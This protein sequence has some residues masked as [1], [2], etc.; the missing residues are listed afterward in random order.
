[1]RFLEALSAK[2]DATREGYRLLLPVRF[3]FLTVLVT[4]VVLHFTDQGKDAVAALAEG[5]GTWLRWISFAA[6]VGLFA[7]QTWYWSRQLLR[8]HY[9]GQPYPRRWPRTTRW[10]PRLLGFT[11]FVAVIVVLARVRGNY[12]GVVRKPAQVLFWLIVVLAIEA[13]VFVAFVIVRRKRIGPVQTVERLR[14]FGPVTL[15]ILGITALMAVIVL[16][17]STFAVQSA[18]HIGAISVLIIA[19]GFWVAL[20]GAV[21]HAGMRLRIPIL[22][23]LLL[24][25]IVIS[26]LAENHDVRTVPGPMP[27]RPDA[28]AAFAAWYARLVAETPNAATPRPVFIVAT[29]GGGVRAAYWTAA[30]LTSLHDTVPGFTSH[31]FGIS[32]ASGGSV[33]AATYRT[34]LAEPT[35]HGALR[36]LARD[37]L[38]Y[39]VLAP[40]LAAYM[41]QDFVQR[42]LPLG[43][44]DRARA[45]E[46]GWE[47][48]WSRA[49]HTQ[50]FGEGFLATTTANADRF[51]SLFLNGTLVETGR[52][53]IG[54]NV[55]IDNHFAYA[56]DAFD[57]IHADV[58]VSTAAH[59]SSRFPYISPAGRIGNR[60]IAD[61]GYFDNSGAST[62][63]D[64]VDIVRRHPDFAKG[65]IRPYVIFIDCQPEEKRPVR[66]WTFANELIAPVMTFGQTYFSHG[67]AA[68][69]ELREH[70]PPADRTTFTLV[71]HNGERFPLGWLLAARTRDLIDRQMSIDA[72]ENGAHVRAIATALGVTPTVDAVS[73]RAR[74]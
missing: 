66:V 34:L 22:S 8:V 16:L 59:N 20:G 27:A 10:V 44:P 25:A 48:G 17:V 62:A 29:E 42:F 51:P 28:D 30:V 7:L 56:V 2:W 71:Q 68:N 69:A 5:E 55:R 35:V 38:A 6:L 12:D 49:V 60:H 26:P 24:F 61:G 19:L 63:A 33:G 67:V 21:V 11:V 73:V 57:L 40:T 70:T 37:A 4:A 43:F 50:R 52:R 31:V 53:A 36:P 23:W 9:R 54:S 46:E 65:L 32:G 74:Q 64:L 18:G 1:M 58:P 39:D 15:R 45:I 72:P 47:L 13:A 3:S 14:D 41:E